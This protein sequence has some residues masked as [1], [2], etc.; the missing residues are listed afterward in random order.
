MDTHEVTCNTEGCEN[1]G[2]PITMPD[3]G[4]PT[5]CG[6]NVTLPD[7]TQRYC[8]TIIDPGDPSKVVDPATEGG[9]S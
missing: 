3:N 4:H 5:F 9:V 1:S 6:A 2:I 7:G 8:G